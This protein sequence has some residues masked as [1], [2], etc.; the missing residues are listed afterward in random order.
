MLWCTII[1]E[2]AVLLRAEVNIYG[3]ISHCDVRS[4]PAYLESVQG[5]YSMT[6][7]NQLFF[8]EEYTGISLPGNLHCGQKVL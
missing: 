3:G 1:L 6:T 8:I 2:D 5:M 4:M 7:S